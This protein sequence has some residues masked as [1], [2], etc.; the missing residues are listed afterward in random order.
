ML[1]ATVTATAQ[2]PVKQNVAAKS[3]SKAVKI[4]NKNL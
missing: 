2:T 4:A 3:G 1:T